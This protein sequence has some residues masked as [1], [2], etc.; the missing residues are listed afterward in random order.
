MAIQS[1]LLQDASTA[2]SKITQQAASGL[3]Q[4]LSIGNRNGGNET[5]EF[6]LDLADL[7]RPIVRFS[8]LPHDASL[9][10]ESICLPI[11]QGLTFNDAASYSTVNMGTIAAM[12]DIAK[13]AGG[14]TGIANKIKAAAGE[15]GAQSFSGGGIGA[16]ILLSRKIG[17]ETTAKT[18]E[19]SSKQ[20]VNPR[21]NTAFD[22]N[23]LRSFQF[24]FKLIASNEAEVRTIDAIQNV[25]RNN[26]Y[27]SE[28]GGRKTMLQY[29]SLWHIEFLSP[30]MTELQY[31]PKIF[32]CYITGAG[33][34][35]N[36]TDNTYRND[37]SPHEVDVSVQFQESKILTRNEI[38]DLETNSNRANADTA[39]IS[40]KQRDLVSA[41][42]KLITKLA[43]DE[44]NTG[45]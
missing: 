45:E 37:Y 33:T 22:G 29:P 11:P 41:Q 10:I 32:S 24:D 43:R 4:N 12:S 20:V 18:L 23:T 40:Q 2:A 19:F 7:Q 13:A 34:T 36:S 16:S 30:D 1:S 44:Q 31:I 39:Y 27:A 17:M 9:P 21:T 5:L 38:E 25:F 42:N 3:Q 14:E 26:T 6:P 15:A 8:C 28:V 35:I